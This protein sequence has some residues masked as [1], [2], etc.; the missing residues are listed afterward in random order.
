[1]LR[2]DTL[3]TPSP[4]LVHSG[5]QNDDFSNLIILPP[6]I[7]WYSS[8]KQVIN[9]SF[10][11]VVFCLIWITC[12]HCKGRINDSFFPFIYSIVCVRSWYK[13]FLQQWQMNSLSFLYTCG[14]FDLIKCLAETQTCWDP[15]LPLI[16][17]WLAWHPQRTHD[18]SG[19]CSLP[20]SHLQ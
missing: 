2:G 11:Q 7:R 1:M 14:P 18:S 17:S 15:G 16:S 9:K 5:L 20:G 13:S 12:F 3:W 4:E 8:V 6:L 19:C 10:H